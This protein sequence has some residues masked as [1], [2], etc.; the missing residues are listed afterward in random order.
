MN[1]TEEMEKQTNISGHNRTTD[2]GDV[3]YPLNRFTNTILHYLNTL[4]VLD[5]SDEEDKRRPNGIPSA[6]IT[7]SRIK[8]TVET[9]IQ[10]ELHFSTV[11]RL[12]GVTLMQRTRINQR[13]WTLVRH[14]EAEGENGPDVFH[15][16]VDLKI[17]LRD[18]FRLVYRSQWF[19]EDGVQDDIDEPIISDEKIPEWLMMIK[20][21]KNYDMIYNDIKNHCRLNKIGEEE[22]KSIFLA[23]CTIQSFLSTPRLAD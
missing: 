17:V 8:N 23:I 9:S 20:E 7:N 3:T 13:L 16:L 14:G 22:E 1:G 4:V 5:K 12:V 21:I 19:R 11:K 6:S 18:S 15:N 10:N 2:I